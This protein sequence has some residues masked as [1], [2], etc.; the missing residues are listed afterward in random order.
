MVVVKSWK[1]EE[2]GRRWSN[3]YAGWVNSR[4]LYNTVFYTEKLLRD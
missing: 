4:D 2:M 3:S 1:V